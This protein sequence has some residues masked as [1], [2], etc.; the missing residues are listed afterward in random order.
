M[1][2]TADN[3][4]AGNDMYYGVTINESTFLTTNFTS[5]TDTMRLIS[6]ISDDSYSSGGDGHG[7][8][9]IVARLAAGDVLRQHLSGTSYSANAH[10]ML[11]ILK[12]GS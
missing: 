3:D 2:R 1:V 11:H 9:M 4:A 12:V 10:V 8:N 7:S 5:V 6:C